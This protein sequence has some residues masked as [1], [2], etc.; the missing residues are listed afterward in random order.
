MKRLVMTFALAGTAVLTACGGGEV[1]VQGQVQNAEGQVR[2]LRDLPVELL[3]YDRDAVFDSLE[4]AYATP[5]PAIPAALASLQDSISR[6]QTEWS[7]AEAVW[8]AGRDSLQQLRRG[9]DALNPMSPQYRVLFGQ[10]NELEGQVNA[11]DRT[12]QAA[13]ARFNQLQQRYNSAADSIQLLRDQWA[14]AAFADV[15]E[16][17]MAREDA[18]GRLPM[19][20]TTDANGTVRFTGVKAGQ[21]WV[22]AR[23]ELPFEELYWNIPVEVGGD[24]TQVQLTRET[25][26]VRPK[27]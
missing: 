15:D 11:A 19:A 23:Y 13:F 22:H 26:Q 12:K 4:N 9:M 3:P 16:A 1:V 8:A 18:S 21:W 7:E 2:A 10:F 5:M 27:L 25:A 20:D 14:D 17:L 24:P 6:A